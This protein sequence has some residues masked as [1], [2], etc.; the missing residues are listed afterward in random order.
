M[1][2]KE[3]GLRDQVRGAA[4]ALGSRLGVQLWPQSDTEEDEEEM[5]EIRDEEGQVEEGGSQ[6]SDSEG[7]DQ[8]EEDSEEQCDK[9]K[10]KGGDTTDDNSSVE[11]SEAGEQA[12]L[13][14]KAD[15]KGETEEKVGDKG[16]ASGGPG[17]LIDLKQFSGSAIWSEE[18]GGE[19]KEG[20]TTAL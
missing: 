15:A 8:E 11:S 10:G 13:T 1:V 12:R 3:G 18:E 5:Q 17:L 6:G 19:G 4:L 20:D 14:D 7:D 9:A 16:E 2:Y